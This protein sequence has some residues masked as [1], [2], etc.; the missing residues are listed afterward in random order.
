MGELR[1]HRGRLHRLPRRSPIS[2][3]RCRRARGA[4]PPKPLS[5]HRVRDGRLEPPARDAAASG[6]TGRSSYRSGRSIPSPTALEQ[7]FWRRLRR[8]RARRR[9]GRVRRASSNAASRAPRELPESPVQRP[10]TRSKTP[11]ST[12]STSSGGSGTREIVVANLIASRLTVLYGPSGVGKSSLLL[13]SVARSLR[14]CREEPLVVVFSRWSE[15]PE[16]GARAGDR[17]GGGL[18]PGQ[19]AEVARAC[20]GGT[21]RVPRSS[22]RRRSTSPTTRRDDGLRHGARGARRRPA[23]CERPA[24]AP[25]GRARLARPAEGCDP[26]PV[27]ERSPPRAARLGGGAC[28]DRRAVGALG[29]SS[30]ASR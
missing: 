8:R 11:I 19:L 21:R 12:R 18:A 5:L 25:R 27:R 7:A 9:A 26:E 17:R 1:D 15:P 30:E 22:T 6:A 29:A 3:P 4:A 14:R 28:R 24:L 16:R 23:T 20:A 2:S 10:R 13:A